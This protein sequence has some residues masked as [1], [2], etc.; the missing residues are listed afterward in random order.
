MIWSFWVFTYNSELNA[1]LFFFFAEWHVGIWGD[2]EVHI[3]EY[4]GYKH[5]RWWLKALCFFFT[6]WH[7]PG[8]MEVTQYAYPPVMF[9]CLITSREQMKAPT[10]I[11]CW[12]WSWENSIVCCFNIWCEIWLKHFGGKKALQ[13]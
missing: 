13:I 6:S 4:L 5:N 3:T 9:Y 1:S 8:F 2:N 10:V 7:T 12:G 11:S